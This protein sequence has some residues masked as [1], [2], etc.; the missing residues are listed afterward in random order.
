[1]ALPEI[2]QETF[3]EDIANDQVSTAHPFAAIAVP[4]VAEAA[5]IFHTIPR[6]VYV[7]Y[8]P[9]LGQYNETFANTLCL[10]EERPDED[11]SDAPH[12]GYSKKVVS[13]AKMFEK[14]FE[15]N[16][17]RVDQKMFLRARLFDMFLGD[18]GRHEDQWRWATFD[19]GDFKI[20]KPIPR[21]RD[22]TWAKFD[23]F[24][25]RK[26]TSQEQLEHLQTFDYKIKNVKKYNFPPRYLDRQLLNEL[27]KQ[28]W[29]TTAQDLQ[30]R[31]TDT[32]IENAVR[33]LPPEI[34]PISGPKIIAKLKSRREHLVQYAE[35]Y[36]RFLAKEVEIVGS[37]KDE[38]FEVAHL[39]NNTTQVRLYDLKKDDTPKDTP[40]YSRIFNEDETHEIRLYGLKGN[41]IYRVQGSGAS[42][43]R[44]RIIGG[45]DRD[46]I[47][48][49]ARGGKKV[50]VYD[51]ENNTFLTSHNTKLHLSLDSSIH[52]YDYK[53]YKPNSGH[54][55]KSPSYANDKG[56]Y[57]SLGY[58]YRKYQWRKEPFGW[59]QAFRANYS[60]SAKAISTE[61]NGL[62]NEAIGKWNIG[63]NAGYNF[64]R[65]GK[66]FGAGNESVLLS[67]KYVDYRLRTNE[68]WGS[69]GLNRFLDKGRHHSFGFGG[70]YQ[71]VEVRDDGG[72][73][74]N[75]LA[76]DHERR[77]FAGGQAGYV[78][79]QVNDAVVATK[80]FH[81][82]LG[83]SHI[84]NLDNTDRTVTRY[85]STLGF[86]LPL[87]K[88][89]SLAVKTGVATLEGEPEFYQLNWIGGG[90]NMRGYSRYRFS[91]KTAFY[92]QNELRWIF[93]ARTY[94]FN[95]K[96]GF[97][98]FLDNGRIWQLGENSDKWHVGY[99]GGFMI[100]PFNKISVTVSYGIS[101]EDQL[102]TVR[103]GS[104][105]R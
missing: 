28:F 14:V 55:I 82:D 81:F 11:Q 98:A 100:A 22:Q 26:I 16:D 43:I 83:A 44:I 86:Y 94:L 102:F 101:E 89:L 72:K 45:P 88:P 75:V 62:F 12:F 2:A 7:P 104:L 59:E 60:F 80:G 8:T 36:Y 61:Y 97:I 3:I 51:D 35:K 46:S 24:F 54:V 96:M 20:Y 92:N 65:L 99:G 78:F 25:P 87:F 56:I 18:W 76:P 70:I 15:E 17:H 21:D 68:Y 31:L 33:Q 32:V 9:K 74:V 10:F 4:P 79:H 13:T 69:I 29:I 66:Y 48:N 49:E 52:M 58:I 90:Q 95:G 30:Q 19:S 77:N 63:L 47:I 23:G 42:D 1:G 50:R 34:F 53:A 93:N 91:G 85:T 39:D 38:L 103:L 5:G 41:D 84:F 40:Y 57:F 6:I 67:K 37:E 64:A 71:S 105:L 27:P 73:F